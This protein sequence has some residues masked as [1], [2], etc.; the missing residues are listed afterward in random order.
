[1]LLICSLGTVISKPITLNKIL[2]C[3]KSFI[4]IGNKG[5]FASYFIPVSWLQ[6]NS[7]RNHSNLIKRIL[8]TDSPEHTPFY[9]FDLVKLI[10]I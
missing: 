3:L 9:V 5:F 7:S 8:E 10:G 4:F 2:Q 6:Y 1:M